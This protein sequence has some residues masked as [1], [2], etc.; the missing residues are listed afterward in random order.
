VRRRGAHL[1]ALALVL[2]FWCVSVWH[3]ERFPPLHGDEPWILAPGYKL[4]REGVFGSDMLAGYA[5]MEAHYVQFLPLFPVLQGAVT[6][7]LGVGVLQLRILPVAAGVVT[8]ALAFRLGRGL[9]G[10]QVGLLAGLLLITWRWTPGTHRFYGSGIPLL[11]LARVA[12]YD[13]LVAPLGLAAL[14][15]AWRA[16]RS[17]RWQQDVLTGVLAGLASLTHVPGFFWLGIGLLWLWA[18]PGGARVRLRRSATLL[19]AAALVWLPWL[20]MV[21]WHWDDFIAQHRAISRTWL[22]APSGTALITSVVQESNRYLLGLREPLTYGRP[23]VWLLLAGLPLA[24]LALAR[25]ALRAGR[26]PG[27]TVWAWLASTAFVPAL[28]AVAVAPKVFGYLAS[29]VPLFC[30]TLAWALQQAGGWR[31]RWARLALALVLLEGAGGVAHLHARAALLGSPSAFFQELRAAVP[32]GRVVG[33]STAWLG[34][35]DRDYAFNLLAY[36]WVNPPEGQAALSYAEAFD[37]LRPDWMLV[38]TGT[39]TTVPDHPWLNE[40]A[41]YARTHGTGLVATVMDPE[42]RRLEIYQFEAR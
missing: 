29:A 28:L 2:V 30:L 42:G 11:D 22:Q 10:P 3:L 37:R 4:V 14:W 13:I 36:L 19:G 7:V 8:V 1:A 17:G 39:N 15:S 5:G 25:G 23:G 31:V 40:N 21:A 12:R 32:P 6:R 18:G 35:T 16:G 24:A 9:G 20:L 33:P 34:L 41:L 38:D 26:R 27:R